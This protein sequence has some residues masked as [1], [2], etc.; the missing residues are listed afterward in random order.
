[1]A[2]ANEEE[3]VFFEGKNLVCKKELFGQGSL[4]YAGYFNEKVI[5]FDQ[6]IGGRAIEIKKEAFIR[7]I[8]QTD[9]LDGWKSFVSKFIKSNVKDEYFNLKIVM[10]MFAYEDDKNGWR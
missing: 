4:V 1:M 3:E 9:C 5:R 6:G 7:R 8:R 2:D 10:Q